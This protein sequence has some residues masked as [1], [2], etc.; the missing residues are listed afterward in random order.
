MTEYN[1]DNIFYKGQY[2]FSRYNPGHL[3]EHNFFLTMRFILADTIQVFI[4]LRLFT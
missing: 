3:H 4:L 2:F 1:F